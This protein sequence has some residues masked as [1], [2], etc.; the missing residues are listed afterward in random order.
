MARQQPD[1]ETFMRLSQEGYDSI[2]IYREKLLDR[3]TPI[4][5]FESFRDCKPVLLLE[6][7]ERGEVWGRFSF[8]IIDPDEEIR[9]SLKDNLINFLEEKYPQQHIYPQPDIPFLG[10]AV[11]FL[12]YDAVKTWEKTVPKKPLQYPCGY[13]LTVNRFLYI[14]HL[15]HTVGAVQVVPAGREELYLQAENWMDQVFNLL[16]EK[17]D[18][19]NTS[20]YLNGEIQSNFS[21]KDF[22]KA[23]EQVKKLIEEGHVSQTVISQKFSVPFQGD[24]FLPY[25]C[26]RS[27]NPSPYMFYL[28]AGD[29]QIAGS[30]PEMLVK[31]DKGKLT[32]KPIAG[33]RKRS[34]LR[35]EVEIIQELLND[36]K[37]N[38]EHI[39]LLD[40]GRNDIGKICLPGTVQVEEF[41]KVERYSHVYHIVSQVS[42]QMQDNYSPWKALQACFPA[43]TVSGAPKV[44][45][46]Q[47]IESL[48]PSARG[49]YAGALGYVGGNG[50]MDTC[51]IIRSL[52]FKEGLASVQAGAGI[53]YDSDP[54]SEFEETQSKAEVLIRALKMA[55]GRD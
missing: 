32:T 4:S 28:D 39:M 55:E 31:L 30:S 46:M 50:N 9:I 16:E 3:L 41:M 26:L 1:Q 19:R 36:E 15:R 53:V 17:K 25:R 35:P 7:A 23:V 38:A 11:G 29:F 12:S 47:I 18:N 45:A 20:F 22:L 2:P 37:E 42:G 40:L 52:F 44:R 43:G 48:E 51:I 54:I 14:D 49:P 5:L 34:Q 27:I 6:S 8:L 10:G 13:F 24:P 21:Q 33:T